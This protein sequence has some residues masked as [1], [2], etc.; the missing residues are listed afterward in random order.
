MQVDEPRTNIFSSEIFLNQAGLKGIA[1]RSHTAVLNRN[2]GHAVEAL[3]RV[4]DM[5]VAKD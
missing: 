5:A 4:D 2:A 1:D 3:R